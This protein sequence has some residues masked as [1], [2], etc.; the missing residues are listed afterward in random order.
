MQE[1]FQSIYVQLKL[2]KS[3]L[4]IVET[5]NK[6]NY[7][8]FYGLWRHLKQKN[9]KSVYFMLPRQQSAFG[10]VWSPKA[11]PAPTFMLYK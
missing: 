1:D 8:M 3:Q 7:G 2:I 4:L 10:T 9:H 5:F 6:G 11:T